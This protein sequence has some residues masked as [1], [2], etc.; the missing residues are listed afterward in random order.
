MLAKR[1]FHTIEIDAS[2]AYLD[3]PVVAPESLQ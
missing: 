2:A 1:G 3:L